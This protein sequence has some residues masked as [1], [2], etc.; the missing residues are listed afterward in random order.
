MRLWNALTTTNYWPKIFK[1][2]E[3]ND[4]NK[5]SSR[6]SYFGKILS[7]NGSFL[8]D[9]LNAFIPEN[10]L[11]KI[12]IWYMTEFINICMFGKLYTY[13][14][15]CIY[16]RR[17]RSGRTSRKRHTSTA[18]TNGKYSDNTIAGSCTLYGSSLFSSKFRTPR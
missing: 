2:N 12:R 13:I 10:I 17:S 3:M 4:V 8:G 11:I 7:Y 9:N 6:F 1:N 16:M 15:K 18:Q 5:S 14:A